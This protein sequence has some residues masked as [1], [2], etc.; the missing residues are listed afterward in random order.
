MSAKKKRGVTLIE[1]IISMAIFAI[2][3]VTVTVAFTSNSNIL[4]KVDMKS[5]LQLD[6]QM[7]QEALSTVALECSGVES[8]TLNRLVLKDSLALNQLHLFEL[9]R[10]SLVY[11][12]I[13]VHDNKEDILSEKLLS[14]YVNSM[15]IEVH[16]NEKSMKYKIELSMTSG[17]NTERLM[18]E[19]Q[20][21]FRNSN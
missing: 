18:M 13:E 8:S 11:K 3:M 14:K 19:N 7:I 17:K 12:V 4:S 10:N 21:V 20:I 15:S 1:L 5:E 16:A 6:A 2:L 9:N